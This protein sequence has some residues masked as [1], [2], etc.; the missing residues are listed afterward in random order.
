MFT[1]YLYENDEKY[2]EV[3]IN[4]ILICSSNNEI[5]RKMKMEENDSMYKT[6]FY[7]LIV[8]E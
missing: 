6:V 2:K 1:L 8:R 4:N 5:Q 7:L 3:C